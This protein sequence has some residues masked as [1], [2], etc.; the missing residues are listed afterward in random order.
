MSIS[1]I[2]C[3]DALGAEVRGVDLSQSLDDSTVDT[4]KRIWAENLV[5]VFRDQ[6]LSDPD[7]IRFSRQFGECDR[8]PIGDAVL[9]RDIP[10]EIT[11]VSN[12]KES[13]EPIGFLGT[14]ELIWHTDMS[15]NPEPAI[16]S[17]LYAI[18]V[19]QGPGGETS[20]LNMYAA[21]ETLPAK[22][23]ARIEGRSAIHDSSYT[24]AG[25]LRTGLD[26]V[27]DV[28]EAPGARHPLMRTHPVTGRTALFLGRRRNAYILGLP[29]EESEALLDELWSHTTQ[30]RFVYTHRWR[31]GDLVFWDNRCVMHRREA[32]DSR[33]RRIMHR[34]QLKGEPVYFQA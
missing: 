25:T 11:V 20:Y 10:P 2:P 17:G 32:F 30:A 6:T 9:N 31:K 4:L 12:V 24:S 18:E 26:E 3:C 7:L 8:A 22:L 15:Y 29:I 14:G 23:L 34:T 5:M 19:A 33:E 16:A 28:R 13:G 1:A 21:F 27:V